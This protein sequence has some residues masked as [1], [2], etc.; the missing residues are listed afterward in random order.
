MSFKVDEFLGAP[1]AL[2][3]GASGLIMG[4]LRPVLIKVLCVVLIRGS[5]LPSFRG[6]AYLAMVKELWGQCGVWLWR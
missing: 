1:L 6:V 3:W 5:Q 4:A 2:L